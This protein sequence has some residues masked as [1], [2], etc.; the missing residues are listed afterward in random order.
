MNAKERK[1]KALEEVKDELRKIIK[2]GDTVY[3]VL[4]HVSRSGM[5]RVIDLYVMQDNQPR[6]ISWQAA[7]LLEGYDERHEGCKVG[8]CGMDMGY[9]LVYKLS[10]S[11]YPVYSCLTPGEKHTTD[12]PSP[13]HYNGEG[14][15][16]T[17]TEHHDGYALK[18]Y[19]L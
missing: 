10:Y 1:D 8:G 16:K 11:L 17:F 13:D 9:H 12:C 19:W 18:H 3:T 2:P 14:W 4:K 15:K 7:Q 5:Y 6:R